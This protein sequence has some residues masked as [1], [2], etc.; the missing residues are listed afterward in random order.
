MTKNPY[1]PPGTT[2]IPRLPIREPVR[3]DI[4]D[5]LVFA[6][7]SAIIGGIA[8]YAVSTAVGIAIEVFVTPHLVAPGTPQLSYGQ[9]A[10]FIIAP[11]AGV[12]GASVG[13]SI[14][15]RHYFWGLLSA[16]ICAAVSAFVAEAVF[17]MWLSDLARY[18]EDPCY[19]VL[20]FP[21]GVACVFVFVMGSCCSVI[22]IVRRIAC[23][24]RDAQQ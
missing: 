22:A 24:S 1:A 2:S 9:Q 14:A 19:I 11:L 7:M 15:C 23:A 18:G 13:V 10:V 20:Y 5:T 4:R 21:L 16:G 3:R 12:L 8:G 6:E 17:S